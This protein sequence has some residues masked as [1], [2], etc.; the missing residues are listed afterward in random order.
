MINLLTRLIA[1]LCVLACGLGNATAIADNLGTTN[2]GM[3]SYFP[4]KLELIKQTFD[5]AYTD[6]I[7][8]NYQFGL[9]DSKGLVYSAVR[10]K[11]R[12]TEGNDVS[13][14]S[15]NWMASMTKPIVSAAIMKMVS[16][17]VISLD[18][19]LSK[20]FPEFG[21]MLVAPGGSYDATLQ[22]AKS[23]ITIQHLISH[24]S[25]LT[26]GT[27]VTGVGDVAEQYDEFEI[28]SCY[29]SETKTMSEHM[30]LLAQ[31]PLI[32]HPGEEWNYSVSTD[33]LGAVV[34]KVSGMPL[35]EYLRDAFFD[36]IGMPNTGFFVPPSKDS[37]YLIPYT[38]MAAA[39]ISDEIDA[40]GIVRKVKPYTDWPRQNTPPN[41]FSGGG[42]LYASVNDYAKFMMML[43][44]GGSANGIQVLAPEAVELLFADQTTQ[45][46]P[47]AF[48]RAFGDDVS[49]FMKFGGGLGIKFSNE[50]V[51]DYY[52]WGGAANTFFW[53][54]R[55]QD[56]IGVFATQL[57]PST[58]NVSD[59]IEE[60]VDQA[61]R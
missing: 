7:I 23:R 11:T 31:L 30:E 22:E 54:D 1:P 43:T 25:G 42:G 16:E 50:T 61:R 8:P 29:G 56:A 55:D 59:S 9:Y 41:C 57:M 2:T 52:F 5:E 3:K 48:Q 20:F 21:D 49:S 10:G 28:M 46:L 32:A 47:D 27:R 4:E 13:L 39:E 19:P 17:G 26:Y 44:N 45:L 14:D 40:E 33:V 37:D 6:G 38:N 34:Q 36:P 35:N 58:Y 24:T 60:I 15:I 53:I 12:L 51:A 18:D